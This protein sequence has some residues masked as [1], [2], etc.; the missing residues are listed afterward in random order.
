MAALPKRKSRTLRGAVIRN[1]SLDTTDDLPGEGLSFTNY[2]LRL[3]GADKL[4][5]TE[6]DLIVRDGVI[7]KA[8]EI[9]HRPSTT[10]VSPKSS[11][12]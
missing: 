2:D 5:G 11:K 6:D 3:P 1:A 9:V 10:T 7:I 8:S 12:P 4:M